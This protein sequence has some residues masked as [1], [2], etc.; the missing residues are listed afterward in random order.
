MKIGLLTV[1]SFNYGSFY[2]AVALQKQLQDMGHEC[3]LIN[4]EF[5]KKE[6]KNLW[7]LYTFH[8]VIPQFLRPLISKILPQYNTFLKLQGDVSGLPQSPAVVTKMEEISKRYDCIV[9]GSDELWSANPGSIR[10][11]PAYFGYGITCPHITYAPSAT[12][13]D[14]DNEK[15]CETVREGMNSYSHIAV[16][17]VHSK[18]VVKKITGREVPVVLDPTLLN[19]FFAKKEDEEIQGEYILIYGQH[20]DEEQRALIKETAKQYQMKIYALGW[21]QDFADGFLNPETAGDFQ[22]AFVKAAYSFPSTFHGTVFSILHRRPFVS[23]LN[24]LRGAK[25][26]MLLE[27]LQLSDR[28]YQEGH[29]EIVRQKIDYSVVFE[30]IDALRKVSLDYLTDALRS[31]NVVNKNHCCG[32]Q[33]CAA[34][35]PVQAI[36]MQTDEEGF[37]YPEIDEEK[38]IHC[39]QCKKN[40]PMTEV[41][42]QKPQNVYACRIRDEKQCKRSAS[43][44]AFRLASNAILQ[45]T[46]LEGAVAG[47]VFDEEYVVK[48]KLVTDTAGRDKMCGSKYVQSDMENIYHEVESALKNKKQVLFTGTPCQCA[49]MKA[50]AKARLGALEENLY[51]CDIVCHGTPSPLIWKEYLKE[52]QKQ[53][54]SKITD[55]T[56]RSKY[57]GW[58]KQ[59]MQISFE[60][61]K[62]YRALTTQDPF[63][64]MYFSHVCLRSSCHSCPFASYERCSDMTMGDFWGIEELKASSAVEQ[65]QLATLQDEQGTSLVFVNTQKGKKL[66]EMMKQDADWYESDLHSCYQAIF[67]NPPKVS[68]KRA[69]FWECFRQ[70]GFSEAQKQYGK[71]HLKEKVVKFIIAPTVKKLGIYNLAQKIYFGR[72]A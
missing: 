10:Y 18:A 43:G 39:G 25:V 24:P 5:K 37:Q 52:K 41:Q 64:I 65:K 36:H 12:L 13:F 29:P 8:K 68:P 30:R 17:D 47:V 20:Y 63:Y 4:E 33:A 3:E 38:C 22:Q 34:I 31:V 1:Y 15:L 26:K 60:N 57:Y 51:V 32:C 21:P 50:F 9:L 48:T 42:L 28:I 54:N 67:E 70:N 14:M 19:P 58:H 53:E 69:A 11:T 59:A 40:C 6:W 56:F 23:M 55:V 49:G 44:G 71:L 45:N 62:I 16:R 35:C 7:L 61:G 46:E 72:K 27:Q 66:W 2:Q